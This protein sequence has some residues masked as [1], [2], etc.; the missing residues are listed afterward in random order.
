MKQKAA[1]MHKT[2]NKMI[3]RKKFIKSKLAE[4]NDKQ[5]TAKKSQKKVLKKHIKEGNQK[6]KELESKIDKK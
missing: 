1:Q 3:K 5:K 4:L 6:L 2:L